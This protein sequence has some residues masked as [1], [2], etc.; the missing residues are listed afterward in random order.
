MLRNV[1]NLKTNTH[2]SSVVVREGAHAEVNVSGSGYS[3]VAP[4]QERRQELDNFKQDGG[5][6]PPGHGGSL[7]KSIHNEI[8]S[9][10]TEEKRSA[11]HHQH[12]PPSAPVHGVLRRFCRRHGG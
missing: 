9:A 5:V 6:L 12:R 2:S 11:Q 4:V 10:E 1:P 3:T 8:F 7:Q